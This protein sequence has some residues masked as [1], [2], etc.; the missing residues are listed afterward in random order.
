MISYFDVAPPGDK[1]QGVNGEWIYQQLVDE[2]IEMAG[3]KL[4]RGRTA[5][6]GSRKY[7]AGTNLTAAPLGNSNCVVILDWDLQSVKAM[8]SCLMLRILWV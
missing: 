2:V 5:A 4:K 8:T 1:S 6:V 7:A 3:T